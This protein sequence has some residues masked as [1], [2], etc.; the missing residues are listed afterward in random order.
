MTHLPRTVLRMI[1][2]AVARHP[3]LKRYLVDAIYRVP[4]FDMRLRDLAHRVVHPE[5]VLDVD[6]DRMPEGSRRSLQRIRARIQR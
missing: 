5:A 1:L 2:N 6:E 4:W 3:R